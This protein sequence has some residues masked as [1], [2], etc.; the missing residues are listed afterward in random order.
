MVRPVD[1]AKRAELLAAVVEYL[2]R[3]GVADLSLRQAGAEIGT[4]ARMLVYYFGTKE[5]LLAEALASTRPDVDT[6]FDTA[7]DHARLRA[8]ALATWG[9]MVRGRQRRGVRLLL[10][11][12][13]LATRPEH[14]HG[15]FSVEQVHAW[16]SPLTMAFEKLGHP[17]VDAEARATALV[18]GLRGLA[19]DRY[20]TRDARRTDAAAQTLIEAVTT[21][22]P[23]DPQ[24]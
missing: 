20:V 1:H 4:S 13:C 2:D 18:S 12:M 24:H 16:I 22:P 11:A 10:Q 19:L 3:H 6:Y 9:D 5:A 7:H 23:A 15:A 14:P 8:I 17:H 21:P